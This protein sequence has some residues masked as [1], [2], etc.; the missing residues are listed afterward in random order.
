MAF[1]LPL[2]VSHLFNTVNINGPY[3]VYNQGRLTTD[4][5]PNTPVV[6]VIDLLNGIAE[7]QK[8]IRFLELAV[9]DMTALLENAIQPHGT[10]VEHLKRLISHQDDDS[11][12]N[13]RAVLSESVNINGTFYMYRPYKTHCVET[14]ALT[15][16]VSEKIVPNRPGYVTSERSE[17]FTE[18]VISLLNDTSTAQTI[19]RRL[20]AAIADMTT[21]IETSLSEQLQTEH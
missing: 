6:P 4:R 13:L 20:A 18:S 8:Q 17:A 9:R 1:S 16:N 11:T 19:I 3:A 10:T 14:I 21:L 7:A 2:L 5:A 15:I 12:A